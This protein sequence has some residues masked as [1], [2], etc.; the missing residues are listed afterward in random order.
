MVK[1]AHCLG[2]K[3]ELEVAELTEAQTRE[4]LRMTRRVKSMYADRDGGQ[5]I[6]RSLAPLEGRLVELEGHGGEVRF[7]IGMKGETRERIVELLRV[8]YDMEQRKSNQGWGMDG[9]SLR[10]LE[11]GIDRLA[12]PETR[13]V[14]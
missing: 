2:M 1:Q 14:E 11:N 4:L 9:N 3:R 6:V 5:R 8:E 7:G 10:A 12:D 13:E